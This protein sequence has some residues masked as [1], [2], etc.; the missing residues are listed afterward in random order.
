MEKA[1]EE[2][3]ADPRLSLTIDLFY[4]GIVFLKKGNKEKENFT[5]RF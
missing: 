2:I 5:I 1:W 3:K 4:I